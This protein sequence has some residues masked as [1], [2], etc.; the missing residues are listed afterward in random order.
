MKE[1]DPATALENL[2]RHYEVQE[3]GRIAY[4]Q[5]V[6]GKPRRHI[7]ITNAVGWLLFGGAIYWFFA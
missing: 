6:E 7:A 3:A 5:G 1:E 4:A 2:K